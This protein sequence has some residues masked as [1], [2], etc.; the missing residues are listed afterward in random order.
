[1]GWLN[2]YA[3]RE[4]MKRSVLLDAQNAS[5]A[6]TLAEV[7]VFEMEGTEKIQAQ[8]ATLITENTGFSEDGLHSLNRYEVTVRFRRNVVMDAESYPMARHWAEEDHN[9][10]DDIIPGS[11]QI[12]QVT[13]MQERTGVTA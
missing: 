11:L 12:Q 13:F 5:H 1:M 7:D 3:V 10:W 9:G 6:K 8:N 4:Q 2:R